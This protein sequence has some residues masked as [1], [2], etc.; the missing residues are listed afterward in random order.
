[1]R[2]VIYKFGYSEIEK[3]EK[4]LSFCILSH[5]VAKFS[6]YHRFS[7]KFDELSNKS[8]KTGDRSDCVQW[9]DLAKMGLKRLA[10]NFAP[11][12]NATLL[13]VLLEEVQHF[14]QHVQQI[15]N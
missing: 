6:N 13:G 2:V 1:M 15:S 9:V 4:E 11:F 5:K 8:T 7:F 14:E 10:Q 3:A 12:H